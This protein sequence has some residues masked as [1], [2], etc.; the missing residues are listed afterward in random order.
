LSRIETIAEGVTLHLGDCREILPTLGKVQAVVTSPPY[1]GI[2]DYG[3]KGSPV[4]DCIS[5]IARSISDGGVIVWN[6]AD[7][8][9]DGTETGTSFKQA[10]AFMGHGLRLHDT[11]V[12]CKEGVTFPDAN[13]YHPAFEYMFVFSNGAPN[14]FNGIKDWKNK[15]GGSKM[16]GTDRLADGSTKRISG[17]GRPV[18]AEGLRRNWWVIANPYTGETAGHPAPMPF[19]LASDH[20]STWTAIR[21]TVMDPY[22]GSG[23]CGVAAVRLGRRFVGI[24]I[25]PKYFDIACRRIS[26]ATKQ[27]DLI[28][29]AEA[30]E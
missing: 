27:T 1:D 11:M 25:E 20:I 15:W 23:T 13:R 3:V 2:R 26:E 21:E 16:H 8:V 14:H 9:V 30:A 28:H 19:A 6:V 12:Y 22:L 18:L 29:L 24:E 5:L 17:H 10:L 7:Q 4:V